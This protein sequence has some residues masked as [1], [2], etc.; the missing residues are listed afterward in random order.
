MARWS[1]Y[2]LIVAAD[3]DLLADYLALVDASQSPTQQNAR[4][5]LAELQKRVLNGIG[6]LDLYADSKRHLRI[7]ADPNGT[8]PVNILRFSGGNA[9]FAPGIAVDEDSVDTHVSLYFFAKG[10]PS[11][12]YIFDNNDNNVFIIGGGTV[13]PKNLL[14]TDA[15]AA[16]QPAKLSVKTIGV[17]TDVDMLLEALGNGAVVVGDDFQCRGAQNPQRTVA[18]DYTFVATD[19][20]L[21]FLHPDSDNIARTWT[22][23]NNTNVPFRLGTELYGS[24]LA[25][26]VTLTSEPPDQLIL[27]GTGN[28]G[29]RSIAAFGEFTA[30]KVTSQAWLVWGTG[31]T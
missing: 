15:G 24:N 8:N 26:V 27:A 28:I 19:A 7:K 31:V 21:S 25:N 20:N 14:Q 1:T 3:A 5:L 29:T 17:E 23:P 4:M 11:A 18:A 22:V 12:A 10:Y 2:P 16:G 13:N 6:F 9:G 30:R